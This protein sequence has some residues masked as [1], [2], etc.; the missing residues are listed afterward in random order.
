VQER[1]N[2]LIRLQSENKELQDRTLEMTARREKKEQQFRQADETEGYEEPAERKLRLS[3]EMMAEE[4]DK[5]VKSLEKRRKR[6]INRG[7]TRFAD[8]DLSRED[9]ADLDKRVAKFD[10]SLRK[11]RLA[12]QQALSE[13]LKG[14]DSFKR[15]HTL[16][17]S[18]TKQESMQLTTAFTGEEN[19][20]DCGVFVRVENL[21]FAL[22]LNGA[23][24]IKRKLLDF[25][26]TMKRAALMWYRQYCQDCSPLVLASYE[27]TLLSFLYRFSTR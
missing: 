23:T 21:E 24:T 5:S 4:T 1:K 7:R 20:N 16:T 2:G 27:A 19:M 12:V 9:L 8:G 25:A 11:A 26:R 22:R 15:R 10:V 3:L 17:A 14:K 18:E 6:L 13:M